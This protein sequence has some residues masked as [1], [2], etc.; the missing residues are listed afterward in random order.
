VIP[1]ASPR[2]VSTLGIVGCHRLFDRQVDGEWA[3]DHFGVIAD[4]AGASM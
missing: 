2:R 4:L 3:S 1:A